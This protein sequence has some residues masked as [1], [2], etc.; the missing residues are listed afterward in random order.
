MKSLSVFAILA[1]A[2]SLL[3][4]A[5]AAAEDR[6]QHLWLAGE[7]PADQAQKH[8]SEPADYMELFQPGSPWPAAASKLGVFK[9]SAQMALRGTDAQLRAIIEGLKARRI[10]LAIEMGLIGGPGPDGCG[11]SLEGY[12]SPAG[13]ETAVKRIKALGGDVDFIAMDEPVWFGHVVRDVRGVRRGCQFSLDE[14]ADRIAPQIAALHRVFPDIQIGDIEPLSTSPSAISQDPRYLEDVMAFADLLQRKTDARL[15][16]LHADVSWKWPWAP[17]LQEMARQARA[18]GIRFGVICDGDA[19]AGGD[20]AW[21]RQAVQRC[22][23]AASDRSI[24]PDE[25]IVQS[26]EPLPTR[27]LPETAPG[28]LTYEVDAVAKLPR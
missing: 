14:L 9:I 21:V 11:L 16:F 15:A 13:P 12:V 19:D 26:W 20:E 28:T 27:M 2:S 10:K 1:F 7:D 25:L 4:G 22:Q 17:R 6:P 5:S 24:R 8:K 3:F 18:R 23:A